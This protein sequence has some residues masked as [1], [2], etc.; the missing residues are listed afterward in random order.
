MSSLLV[1]YRAQ[2]AITN[3]ELNKVAE[4]REALS[5]R[6]SDLL[7]DKKS[8][9]QLIANQEKREGVAPSSTT[10]TSVQNGAGE[11][12]KAE[13]VRRLLRLRPGITPAGIRAASGRPFD[14]TKNFPYT[15]LHTWKQNGKVTE[16]NGGYF[17]V[18][19]EGTIWSE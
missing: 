11:I 1:Q 15:M 14:L 18:E 5:E 13:F 3:E 12:S 8:L 19:G 4:E 17:L 9:L 16:K 6:E 2:L 7:L 10:S